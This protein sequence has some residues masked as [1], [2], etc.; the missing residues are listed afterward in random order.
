VNSEYKNEY[1]EKCKGIKGWKA[2][3]KY[4]TELASISMLENNE[5]YDRG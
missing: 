2:I 4:N 3:E 1:L 5:S